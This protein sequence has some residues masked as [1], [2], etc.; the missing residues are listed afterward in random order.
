MTD[1]EMAESFV[2]SKKS[3]WRQGRTCIESVKQAFLV[4]LKAGRDMAEADIATVAYMQ[5]A[6]RYKKWH[7]V[8]DG[9]LP[10]VQKGCRYSANILTD[11]GDIAYYDPTFNTWWYAYEQT[12]LDSL[13]IDPPPVAWFE[14]P[15]Y[16]E[17]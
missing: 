2:G 9:D 11:E 12:E 15:K 8:A 17:E 4:G 5:G 10:P 14:L 1:E 6:E 3:F 7:K 13:E 16:T